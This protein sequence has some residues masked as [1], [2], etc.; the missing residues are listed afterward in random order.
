M[1]CCSDVTSYRRLRLWISRSNEQGIGRLLYRL[2]NGL[3]GKL[4]AADIESEILSLTIP[5]SPANCTG[6]PSNSAAGFVK[7]SVLRSTVGFRLHRRYGTGQSG[8]LPD[9]T[10]IRPR[11]SWSGACVPAASFAA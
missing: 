2:C 5:R 4:T 8:A 9:L 3:P 1:A 10:V 11:D 7:V 6:P